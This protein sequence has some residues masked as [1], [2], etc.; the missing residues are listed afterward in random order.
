METKDKNQIVYYYNREK[1]MEKA[2]PN[3]RFMVD[4]YNGKR[5]G[6][7]RSLTATRSLRYLFFA[8]VFMTIAVLVVSYIQGSRN[9]GTVGGVNLS[10]SAMWFEGDVYVSI[11]RRSPWYMVFTS[12]AATTSA[13]EIRTGDGN[14]S[15]LGYMQASDQE[16]KLRFEAGIK[17]ERIA[18]LASIE[19][20]GK[21]ESVELVSRVE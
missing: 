12:S 7:F 15:S 1:R 3:A 13:I 2:G 8:V 14:S 19:K 5:P 21:T 20:E 6:I 16:I 17:P 4:H 9:T 18:V 10:V 11:K